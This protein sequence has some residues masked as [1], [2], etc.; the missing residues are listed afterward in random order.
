MLARQCIGKTAEEQK[1]PVD[2]QERKRFAFRLWSAFE[3]DPFEDGM[4]HPAEEIIEKAMRSTERRRV[5]EWLRD[6][7]LD[8]GHPSFSSGVLRCLSRQTHPGT[9]AWRAELVRDALTMEDIE[10]RDAAIQAA[11]SWGGREMVDV[12]TSHDEPE[13]WLREY[14][15]DVIDDLREDEFVAGCPP[16]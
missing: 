12:L 8:A 7:S 11:E 14:I 10:I 1:V 2:D 13:S 6:L 3:T 5:L 4:Y 16:A 15:R 9:A